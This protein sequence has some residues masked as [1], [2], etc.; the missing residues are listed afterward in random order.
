M[1]FTTATYFEKTKL[2]V[3]IL[4]HDVKFLNND[5]E[6]KWKISVNVL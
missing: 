1:G 5:E 2:Q 6:E 3:I 4:T